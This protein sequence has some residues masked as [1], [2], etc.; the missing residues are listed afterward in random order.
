MT[1]GGVLD[2]RLLGCVGTPIS[3]VLDSLSDRTAKWFGEAKDE[4]SPSGV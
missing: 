3:P 4:L 1:I 2:V